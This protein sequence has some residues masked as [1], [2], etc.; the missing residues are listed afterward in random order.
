MSPHNHVCAVVH[1]E[2]FTFSPL[3]EMVTKTKLA[4]GSDIRMPHQ[5]I[6]VEAAK[7]LCPV[8]VLHNR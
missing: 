4:H 5:T 8:P 1:P 6:T 2:D 7:L 3:V